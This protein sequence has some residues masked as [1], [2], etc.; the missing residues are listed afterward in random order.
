MEVQKPLIDAAKSVGIAAYESLGDI[1]EKT[2]D[3]IV[4]F[5]VLEHLTVDQLK[6]LFAQ[7]KMLLKDNGIML[8]RFPNADSFVGLASQNGDFTHLTAIGKLKLHQIIT[9]LDLRIDNFESAIIYPRSK[10][11]HIIKTFFQYVFMKLMDVGNPY[12]FS[13][14]VIAVIKHK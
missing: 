13:G 6:D 2:F 14:D 1:K 12:Y 10:L 11:T 5:D 8:F 4:G 3:L 7:S 9:P